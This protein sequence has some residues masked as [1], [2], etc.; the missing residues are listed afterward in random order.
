MLGRTNVGGGFANIKAKNYTILPA[1]G[2]QNDIAVL[3]AAP[4]TDT[5]ISITEPQTPI[6]GMVWIQCAFGGTCY[7]NIGNI[8]IYLT[9]AKQRVSDAWVILTDWYC[10]NNDQWVRGRVYLVREG[11]LVTEDS[12]VE[13]TLKLNSDT[14]TALT[15]TSNTRDPLYY[16]IKNTNSSGHNGLRGFRS[17]AGAWGMYSRLVV[18]LST[19]SSAL[20]S[21]TYLTIIPTSSTFVTENPVVNNNFGGSP[22]TR[23][24]HTIEIPTPYS[25]P[26]Y[27][28]LGMTCAYNGNIKNFTIFNVYLE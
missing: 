13:Y 27:V 25:E 26:C 23:V 14:S 2:R 3:N 20:S 11:S 7:L 19:S 4:I 6:E 17:A 24:T 1:T 28:Y 22:T 21:K 16:A 10:Y 5:V 12:M 15:V 18:E 9:S 8:K